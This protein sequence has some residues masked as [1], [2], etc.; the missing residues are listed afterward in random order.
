MIHPA[1][2]Y[3]HV[4]A[5]YDTPQEKRDVQLLQRLGFDVLNPNRPAHAAGAKR[6]GMEYFKGLVLKC[7]VLAFRALPDGSIS[8]GVAMEIKWA[9]E[10]D[11]PVFEL[12]GS[13]SRR[14]LTVE[15]TRE[16][17]TEVGQR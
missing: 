2:Y 8:S 7:D 13:V 6:E 11:M 1:V 14:C 4:M 5:L 10:A 9:Q 12:P 17:L 3:A 16:Y 15:Q